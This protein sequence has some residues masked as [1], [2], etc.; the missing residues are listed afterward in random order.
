MKQQKTIIVEAINS[1]VQSADEF[2]SLA[3]S[4]LIFHPHIISI[5][6]G[7]ILNINKVK[8]TIYL[9]SIEVSIHFISSYWFSYIYLYQTENLFPLLDLELVLVKTS[10]GID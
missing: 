6:F 9:N 5:N 8:K 1:D 3:N 2:I 7:I 4:T 10:L